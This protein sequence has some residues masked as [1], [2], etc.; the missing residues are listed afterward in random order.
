MSKANDIF[1]GLGKENKFI[2]QKSDKEESTQ[3]SN[4]KI[5]EDGDFTDTT[6]EDNISETIENKSQSSTGWF[7]KH[8][9]KYVLIYR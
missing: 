3:E 9:F 6:V 4:A 8:N 5:K 2:E 7:Y 1:S